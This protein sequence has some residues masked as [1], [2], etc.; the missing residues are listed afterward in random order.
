MMDANAAEH[1]VTK[2]KVD[3]AREVSDNT[4]RDLVTNLELD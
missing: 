3:V 1:F 4:F 2:A